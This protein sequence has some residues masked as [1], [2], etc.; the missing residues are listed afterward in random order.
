MDSIRYRCAALAAALTLVGL[1]A[2]CGATDQNPAP[3]ASG[4]TAPTIS[5]PGGQGLVTLPPAPPSTVAGSRGGGR[6][7]TAGGSLPSGGLPIGWPPELPI[8]AGSITGSTRSTGRW[9]VLIVAT[10]SAAEVRRATIALYSSAGF[11]AVSDSV[12]NKGNRQITLVT[13]N[14]DHSATQTALVVQLTT[15]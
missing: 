13:E 2:G 15:S 8:P 9:T 5:A 14:R 1:A 12:L 4:I 7:G 3:S 11:T 10:G 6:G